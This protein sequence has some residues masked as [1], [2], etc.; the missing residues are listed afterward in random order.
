MIVLTS[1]PWVMMKAQ[2]PTIT[3]ASTTIATIERG[4]I[5]CLIASPPVADRPNPA[6]ASTIGPE[7][8]VQRMALAIDIAD[9]RRPEGESARTKSRYF[10]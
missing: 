7:F 2:A 9:E 10:L 1:R 3:Q 4:P 6:K 5:E 8:R